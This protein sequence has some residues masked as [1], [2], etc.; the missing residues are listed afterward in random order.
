MHLSLNARKVFIVF[1]VLSIL[2]SACAP[3]QAAIQ[4]A[5]AQTQSAYTSIPEIANTSIPT[6]VF[7]TLTPPSTDIPTASPIPKPGTIHAPIPFNTKGTL[8]DA[9]SGATFDL[10]V[11]QVVRGQQAGYLIQQASTKILIRRKA[12]NIF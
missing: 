3:S 10:Q 5:I 1:F 2:L 9:P 11:Q 4:T 7:A 8:T 6:P 12:W